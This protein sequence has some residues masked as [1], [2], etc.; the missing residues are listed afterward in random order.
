[1]STLHSHRPTRFAALLGAFAALALALVALTACD[2]AP[3]DDA[4]TLTGSSA[5]LEA[6]W[7]FVGTDLSPAPGYSFSDDRVDVSFG[8][9]YSWDGSW[10]TGFEGLVFARP[11]ELVAGGTYALTLTT[12]DI[13][14]GIP[15]VLRASLPGAGDAQSHL[16]FGAGSATLT[17][18]VAS[19]PGPAPEL[20][21]TA[22]PAL[23]HIGPLDH[24]GILIQSYRFTAQLERVD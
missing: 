6:P 12:S 3:E 4:L 22:H 11:A 20:F 17:F 9:Y 13:S 5:A 18:T 1:M 24:L 7:R 21:V 19:D 23:G 15:V 8:G 14:V 16:F 2:A 10:A